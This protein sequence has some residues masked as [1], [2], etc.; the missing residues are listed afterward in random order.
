ML[1]T[2]PPVAPARRRRHHGLIAA[3]LA[4]AV[5]VSGCGDSSDANERD[6]AAAEAVVDRIV[7]A[8]N[9]ERVQGDTATR[10]TDATGPLGLPSDRVFTTVFYSSGAAGARFD[11]DEIDVY[12]AI[13]N[14]FDR[15]EPRSD[16]PNRRLT[17]G[18]TVRL[19]EFTTRVDDR[20]VFVVVY[21]DALGS[22]EVTADT[23]P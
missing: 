7:A 17:D 23:G 4:F 14:E 2:D 11:P 3:V 18:T 8:A 15:P 9:I 20:S 13:V 5:V 10:T 6:L 22:L 12:D 21:V 16:N 1:V 19:L